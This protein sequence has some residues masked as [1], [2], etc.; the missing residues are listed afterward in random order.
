MWGGGGTSK[1]PAWECGGGGDADRER[2]FRSPHPTHPIAPGGWGHSGCSGRTPL[3]AAG[4]GCG[5]TPP[6]TPGDAAGTCCPPGAR[7]L[8]G[9]TGCSRNPPHTPDISSPHSAGA[10]PTWGTP[11][12]RGR[13]AGAAAGTPPASPTRSGHDFP[14]GTGDRERLQ[15]NRGTPGWRRGGLR[16]P[17]PAACPAASPSSPSES[18]AGLRRR[19]VWRHGAATE[20]VPAPGTGRGTPE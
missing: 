3:R 1:L 2:L 15:P 6:R 7:R 11:T 10:A 19:K 12:G 5:R 14:A 17:P 16:A 18:H 13:A 4:T 9:A 20:G 8:P